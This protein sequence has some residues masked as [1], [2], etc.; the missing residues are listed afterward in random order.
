MNATEHIVD[1]HNQQDNMNYQSAV[2]FEMPD[3]DKIKELRRSLKI[4]VERRG[5]LQRMFTN[6]A[7]KF[8][9]IFENP[10]L[11]E[12]DIELLTSNQ[13]K[14]SEARPELRELDKDIQNIYVMLG[15]K[16][17]ADKGFEEADVI[18]ENHSASEC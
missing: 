13:Q 5:N 6:Q 8:E 9:L 3:K 11:T 14:L 16:G 2:V 7:K 15:D 12:E 17:A 1:P 10:H 4:A 18:S